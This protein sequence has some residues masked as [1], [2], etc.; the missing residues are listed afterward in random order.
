MREIT[1]GMI[2][3]RHER[4]DRPLFRPWLKEGISEITLS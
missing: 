4:E 3:E 1:G 2:K